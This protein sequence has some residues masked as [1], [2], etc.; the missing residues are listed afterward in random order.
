MNTT[1]SIKE[2]TTSD[3]GIIAWFV[4]GGLLFL[5]VICICVANWSTIK[6]CFEPCQG[7]RL[8]ENLKI[9]KIIGHF[10][11][12]PCTACIEDMHNNPPPENRVVAQYKLVI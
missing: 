11:A 10:L 6:E 4:I 9:L 12:S 8:E 5:A 1:I 3:T 2:G 7:E